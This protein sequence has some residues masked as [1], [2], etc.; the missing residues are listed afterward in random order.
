[1]DGKS[2]TVGVTE[3]SPDAVAVS[4]ASA[5]T[6][7]FENIK[8]GKTKV[9]KVNSTMNRSEMDMFV[10]LRRQGGVVYPGFGDLGRA[11]AVRPY[12][13]PARQSEGFVETQR[14]GITLQDIYDRSAYLVEY[15]DV[16][17]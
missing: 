8:C 10:E 1:V 12:N 2:L 5:G 15:T 17:P 7:Q 11:D 16:V 4:G 13:G 9:A 14:N 3:K 6:G